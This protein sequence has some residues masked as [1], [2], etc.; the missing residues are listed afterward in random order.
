MS[1]TTKKQENK[2][3]NFPVPLLAGFMNDTANVVLD[4]LLYSFYSHTL[5]NACTFNETE[6]FFDFNFPD[7]E[8][9]EKLGREIYNKYQSI[10]CP[11]VGLNYSILCN[12]LN[13][14]AGN[15]KKQDFQKA[16]FLAFLALKSIIGIKSWTKTNYSLMFARMDGKENSTEFPEL[17]AEVLKFHTEHYHRAIIE[18]LEMNWHLKTVSEN[19]RGF[20]ASFKLTQEQL[21]RV[22]LEKKDAYKKRVHQI[23]KKETLKRTKE[24]MKIEFKISTLNKQAPIKKLYGI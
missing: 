5:K 23:N 17:S 10:K 9:A 3:L 13:Q 22:A 15:I 4:I 14:K 16:R 21:N 24:E 1:K 2:Y 7:S 18:E 6:I 19:V 8:K 20:Y 11:H 12:F